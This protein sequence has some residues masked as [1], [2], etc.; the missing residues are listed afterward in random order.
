MFILSNVA[1]K[2]E[3]GRMSATPMTYRVD[4][5]NTSVDQQVVLQQG[6]VQPEELGA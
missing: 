6:I 4:F 3:D 2:L 5:S 1:E